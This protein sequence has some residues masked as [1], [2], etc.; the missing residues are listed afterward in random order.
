MRLDTWQ[1]RVVA[2]GFLLSMLFAACVGFGMLSP[3]SEAGRYPHAD[4]IAQNPETYV[5]NRVVMSGTVIRT[6]PLVVQAEYTAVR[7]GAFVKD[8]VRLTVT[9]IEPILQRGTTVQVFGTMT[10]KQTIHASNTI[11]VPARNYLYMY[12]ISF[13]A[14]LWVLVRLL[15]QWRIEWCNL[16]LTPRSS[17][18]SL[19]AIAS[20]G[21]L[22]SEPE[23]K[24]A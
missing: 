11:V 8:T 18:L 22:D 1:S 9:D 10:D 6:D 23:D 4:D 3:N 17:P 13:I 7:N 14:G 12:A 21:R 15:Q 24:N 16:Q 2:L 19:R 5:D 20:A